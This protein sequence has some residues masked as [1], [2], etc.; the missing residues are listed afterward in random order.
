MFLNVPLE[1]PEKLDMNQILRNIASYF[2]APKQRLI[3]MDAFHFLYL[4]ILDET[5]K[6]LGAGLAKETIKKIGTVKTDIEA[7]STDTPSKQKMLEI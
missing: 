5:E 7:F 4:H 2:P 3:F 1:E 6:F